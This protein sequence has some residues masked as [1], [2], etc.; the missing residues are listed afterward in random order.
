MNITELLLEY[1]KL[2][3]RIILLQ[4]QLRAKRDRATALNG[5]QT[6]DRVQSSH[7]PDRIGRAVAELADRE[8]ELFDLEIEALDKMNTAEEAL[9]ELKNP[10]YALVLQYKY[11]EGLGWDEVAE[12]MHYSARWV[13]ELK[14]R[15]FKELEKRREE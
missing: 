2:R 11:I 9:R 12:N 13:Q 4:A 1:A 5:W 15:A 6:G 7:D 8:A 10:D 3:K 14:R